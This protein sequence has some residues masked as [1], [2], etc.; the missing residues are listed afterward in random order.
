MALN[1]VVP[2]ADAD[3]HDVT[4]GT[5]SSGK[6]E[7]QCSAAELKNAGFT[8]SELK[9]AGFDFSTLKSIGF[10]LTQLKAA[11]FCASAYK[12]AGYELTEIKEI[13]FSA[14]ELKEAGFDFA[15]LQSAAFNA[16]QLKAAGFDS[17]AFRG[18]GYS[19]SQ[20]KRIGFTAQEIMYP[21]Q[22]LS[23]N[24]SSTQSIHHDPRIAIRE[25][26][27]QK[28][29]SVH[30]F[31]ETWRSRFEFF[32]PFGANNSFW[33]R[34]TSSPMLRHFFIHDANFAS[35]LW[36][37]S[38]SEESPS[39]KVTVA[40]V[41]SAVNNCALICAL[42]LSIPIGVI[43]NLSQ[44][45][46]VAMMVN[47]GVDQVCHEL[48]FKNLQ[49]T[50]FSNDCIDSFKDRF[51][52]LYNNCIMCFYSSLFTLITAVLYYMCRPSESYNNAS[53]IML[54]NA[55]TL[56]LRQAIRK[57]IGEGVEE[58][59]DKPFADRSLENEVFMKARFMAKNEAEE[60]K[61]QEFYIWYQSKNHC[62]FDAKSLAIVRFI[63]S[64]HNF[65]D[66]SHDNDIFN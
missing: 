41:D 61:N 19:L 27:E 11:G 12:V 9:R 48:D 17:S 7:A 30:I 47:Q 46:F 50:A 18:A 20:L 44:D 13:G 28:V 15:S 58:S 26:V 8:A 52:F 25:L 5:L 53:I 43:S 60:Q 57:E 35:E 16:K 31:G 21:S 65:F 54:M 29:A 37:R 59:A 23:F 49:N 56:D 42:L 39:P 2:E 1:K 40:D 64:Y 10:T 3:K 14:K 34:L 4:D 51:T 22:C 66:T 32:L 38:L 24:P 55:F 62:L 6:P 36:D 45:A 63:L 33:N